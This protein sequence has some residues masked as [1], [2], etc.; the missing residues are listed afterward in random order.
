MIERIDNGENV[1]FTGSAGAGKSFLLNYLRRMWHQSSVTGKTFLAIQGIAAR[2]IRGRTLASW[3]GAGKKLSTLSREELLTHISRSKIVSRRWKRQRVLVIDEISM[4]DGAVFD[5]LEWVARQVRQDQRPF[6]GIQLVLCG[7]FMQ[8]PS[9]E[10]PP[11]WCFNA[12]SWPSCIATK[13]RLTAA[14]RH[15]DDT[16]F[17]VI[18]EALRNGDH[19]RVVP[20]LQQKVVEVR[21]I[22]LLF[23]ILFP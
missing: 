2:R 18:C 12:E 10:D 16:E 19:E 6:G 1:F 7:D 15:K 23:R 14:P 9:V 20:Y 17:A 13:L 11:V 3:S 22:D 21:R 8:L 4:L 5:K